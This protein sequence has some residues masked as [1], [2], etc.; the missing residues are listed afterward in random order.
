VTVAE[1]L[2]ELTGEPVAAI[3]RVT[4]ENFYRLFAP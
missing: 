2:A 1:K 3:A 4:R